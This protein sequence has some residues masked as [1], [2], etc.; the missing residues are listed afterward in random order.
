VKDPAFTILEQAR[1]GAG[2]YSFPSGHTQTAVGTFGA[3][4]VN[5]KRK[6]FRILC[7]VL[8]VLVGFSRMYVGVHTPADVLAGALSSVVL[9]AAARKAVDSVKGM[10]YMI[11][12]MLAMSLGLMLFVRCYSFP[13]DVDA[14]NLESGMKN[15]YTMFG[16]MIGV[17]LVY[18][19]D[20]KWLNF[21]TDAVW[22]AQGLKILGG[23]LL[24]VAAKELLRAP[25]DLVFG[26]H[27]ISRSVRYFIMVIIG[28]GLWP[29]TFK[30]FSKLGR[31]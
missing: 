25:L 15:A 12:T 2:G 13:A 19:A 27:L 28:G 3:L 23:L 21:S 31:K 7:I 26:G 8:G 5:G 17:A 11:G 20:T 1:E 18:T 16:C 9:I 10:K 14:H 30:W 24:V 6:W 4:A 22:W 29:M